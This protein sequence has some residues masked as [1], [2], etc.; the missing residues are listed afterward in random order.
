MQDI[1]QISTPTYKRLFDIIREVESIVEENVVNTGL[2]KLYVQG[3]SA[4]IM[5]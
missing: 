1:I 3:A 4:A 5:I 2:A